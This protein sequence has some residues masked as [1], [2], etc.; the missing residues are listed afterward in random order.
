MNTG[1]SRALRYE[2][3]NY[4]RSV[5]VL[6]LVM[7]LI[8]AGI[9][10][11]SYLIAGRGNFESNFNGF[12]AATSV[13]GLVLG[14][15][16][17]RENQRLLNQ[18]G[19]S[20][21][22]A[23]LADAMALAA[24]AALVAAGTTVILGVYQAILGPN[25]PVLITDLYQVIYEPE[26]AGVRLGTLVRGGVFSAATGWMLAG[27]GQLCSALY[28]RLNKF[29]TLVVSIGVPA[30]LIFG[31]V[32]L[33]NWL[34]ATAAGRAAA[35]GLAAFSRFLVSSPWNA[36]VVFLAVGAVLFFLTWLLLRRA[37]IR[38]AK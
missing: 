13:F 20:R 38:A 30:L 2:V 1:L 16:G 22:T 3:Q 24:A 14:M 10:I 23:F 4:S 5:A 31:S 19:I 26:T 11:L 12:S 7:A 18:N 37:A 33:A 15:V 27:L 21:R 6:W 34:S 25:S 17:L 28:W 32:P 29:W 35:E 9:L 36:I 8:P